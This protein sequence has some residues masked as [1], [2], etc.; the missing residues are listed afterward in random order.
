MERLDSIHKPLR[1]EKLLDTRALLLDVDGVLTKGEIIYQDSGEEIKVFSVR[2]GLGIRLLT[3]A[4]IEV[5]VVTGRSSASLRH[6]CANLN[7]RYIFDG[8]EN[9]LDVLP[10]ITDKLRVPSRLMACMGDDLPD[11]ALLQ[12]VGV[13]IA[14]ADAHEVVR[15]TAAMITLAKGGD[16][17]VREVCDAL[18]KAQGYWNDILRRFGP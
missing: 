16:G 9:K 8:V 1:E 12:S 3:E 4:G 2:D 10:E 15:E 11:V 5:A 7:I 14:V 17:A 18:L 6:R 13:S